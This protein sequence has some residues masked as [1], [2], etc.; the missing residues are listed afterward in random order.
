MR[1][2]YMAVTGVI[3]QKM[4]RYEIA[5]TVRQRNLLRRLVDCGGTM[6]RDLLQSELK[7]DCLLWNSLMRTLHKR[8][9]LRSRCARRPSFLG[10]E[11]IT[12]TSQ[13]RSACRG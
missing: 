6:Q 3:R 13:G 12:I 5:L 1:W 10:P 4:G 8:G 7:V 9:F 11:M 2:F